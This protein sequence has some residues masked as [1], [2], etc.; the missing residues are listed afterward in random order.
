MV[1]CIDAVVLGFLQ[2]KQQYY[3]ASVETDWKR[4][5]KPITIGSKSVSFLTPQQ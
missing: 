5:V 2:Q 1:E 4:E 3:W